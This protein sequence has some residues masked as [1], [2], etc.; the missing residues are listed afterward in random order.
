MPFNPS[1]PPIRAPT[2]MEHANII[3]LLKKFNVPTQW[4]DS[5]IIRIDQPDTPGVYLTRAGLAGEPAHNITL[6]TVAESFG[7]D[8]YNAKGDP[9][10]L[11]LATCSNKHARGHTIS[12]F[13][14]ANSSLCEGLQL[15][16]ALSM[17]AAIA[18]F[19]KHCH[20]L[21]DTPGKPDWNQNE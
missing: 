4:S 19:A 9:L 11:W 8:L 21:G 6:G 13:Y 15:C 18:R 2:P 10:T 7:C 12:A 14:P 3:V 16:G 5:I 20:D 1:N 17:Y